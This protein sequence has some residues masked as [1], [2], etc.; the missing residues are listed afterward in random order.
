MAEVGALLIKIIWIMYY[1]YFCESLKN[2]K[3]YVGSTSK[4]PDM[5][6]SEHNS[7]SSK[8]TRENAPFKLIYFEEY[9]CK[10]DAECREWFYKSG[11]GKRIK[12]AIIESIKWA[13][14]SAG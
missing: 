3:I 13:R 9:H 14:S 7:G 12:K 6:V 4:D 2:E 10:K 1:T 5:R 8:W 11:L